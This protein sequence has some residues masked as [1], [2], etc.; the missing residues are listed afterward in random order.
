[1]ERRRRPFSLSPS[2]IK[3]KEVTTGCPKS[4]FLVT[5]SYVPNFS[6]F[7]GIKIIILKNGKNWQFQYNLRKTSTL[8]SDLQQKR[9]HLCKSSEND[10][11]FFKNLAPNCILETYKGRIFFFDNVIVMWTVMASIDVI[12]H[13]KRLKRLQNKTFKKLTVF[14]NYQ[15]CLI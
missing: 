13:L 3:Q 14:K 12:C 10:K 2:C 5:L 4:T 9:T 1:M 6:T 8:Q 7:K 15:K 11:L